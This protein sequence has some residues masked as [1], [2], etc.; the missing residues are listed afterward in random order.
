MRHDGGGAVLLAPNTRIYI[1][2]EDPPGSYG[3][4]TMQLWKQVNAGFENLLHSLQRPRNLSIL[5]WQESMTL[6]PIRQVL[7][8]SAPN[9]DERTRA[10]RDAK[11][12]ELSY[13]GLTVS[14]R[15]SMH[16]IIL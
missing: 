12:A 13:V 10:W 6:D 15:N 9:G 1:G 3:A 8:A 16:P 2:L 11:L 5:P 14:D 4:A 7:S